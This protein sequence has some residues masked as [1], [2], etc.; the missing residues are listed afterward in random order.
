MNHKIFLLIVHFVF[1]PVFIFAQSKWATPTVNMVDCDDLRKKY[2]ESI[3]KTEELSDFTRT[4]C[5]SYESYK[6]Y[7]VCPTKILTKKQKKILETY[8]EGFNFLYKNPSVSIEDLDKKDKSF[9]K[10]FQAEYYYKG[11]KQLMSPY[12]TFNNYQDTIIFTNKEVVVYTSKESKLPII[13]W[14]G[15]PF[16]RAY[17]LTFRNKIIYVDMTLNAPEYRCIIGKQEVNTGLQCWRYF[18]KYV[19]NNLCFPMVMNPTKEIVIPD[20]RM[21]FYTEWYYPE[22]YALYK[23]QVK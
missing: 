3:A 5:R 17:I 14:R 4:G 10:L 18:Y 16:L 23:A 2:L 19:E 9:L 12:F 11:E 20:W 6:G 13:E 21:P 22:N 8:I 1:L 7:A 15:V